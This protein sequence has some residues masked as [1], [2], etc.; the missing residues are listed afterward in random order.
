VLL[1]NFNLLLLVMDH[2]YQAQSPSGNFM[3]D[4]KA[5]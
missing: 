3:K 5:F 4:C 1:L 2:F